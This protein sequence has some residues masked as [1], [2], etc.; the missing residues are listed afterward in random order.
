VAEASG[1]EILREYEAT[2]SNA[3]RITDRGTVPHE[4]SQEVLDRLYQTYVGR[5]GNQQPAKG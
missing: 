5:A 4:A 2:L 1:S 3:L